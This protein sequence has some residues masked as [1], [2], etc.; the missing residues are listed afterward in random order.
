[1]KASCGAGTAITSLF[2]N[3]WPMWHARSAMMDICGSVA[4]SSTDAVYMAFL[5]ELWSATDL[6]AHTSHANSLKHRHQTFIREAPPPDQP[7]H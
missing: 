4:A 5:P 1:M 7:Q 2:A 3:T 6:L